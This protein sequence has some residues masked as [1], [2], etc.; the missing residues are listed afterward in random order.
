VVAKRSLLE[1]AFALA[2]GN[3]NMA[4]ALLRLN[5]NY[6]YTLLKKL[7]LTH[8]RRQHMDGAFGG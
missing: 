8:L 6:V 4:A 5:R 1:R 7:D 2:Q 3:H